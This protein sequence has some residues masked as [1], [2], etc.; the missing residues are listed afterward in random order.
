MF[1]KHIY[2]E[3]DSFSGTDKERADDLMSFYQDDSIAA[4][5]DISGGDLANGVLKYLDWDVI[6][7]ANKIFWDTVILQL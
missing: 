6:A 5:Y 1:A 3:K 7:A 4:I 2:A